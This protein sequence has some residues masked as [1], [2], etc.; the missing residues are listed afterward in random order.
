MAKIVCDFVVRNGD[1]RI[2]LDLDASLGV[3]TDGQVLLDP[4]VVVLA[5]ADDTKL[6]VPVDCVVLYDCVAT[7]VLP[8]LCDDT[9]LLVLLQGVHDDGWLG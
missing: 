1:L 4:R 5:S 2:I 8:R 6:L 9:T 7:E 3:L